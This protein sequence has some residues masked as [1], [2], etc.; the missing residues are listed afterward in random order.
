MIIPRL[1]LVPGELG[2]HC[3]LGGLLSTKQVNPASNAG[4]ILAHEP[5]IVVGI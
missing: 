5:K 2:G 1:I 3:I 4:A